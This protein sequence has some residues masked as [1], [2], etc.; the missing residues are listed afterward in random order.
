[1]MTNTAAAAA[2]PV[3][4]NNPF[5][6]GAQRQDHHPDGTSVTELGNGCSHW[7]Q[8]DL[9]RIPYCPSSTQIALD[10]GIDMVASRPGVWD[11]WEWDFGWEG[12]VGSLWASVGLRQNPFSD[13]GE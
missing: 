13:S 10:E 9:I 4:A 3:C 7:G 1:M 2:A 12:S 5:S 6:N 11:D 8:D